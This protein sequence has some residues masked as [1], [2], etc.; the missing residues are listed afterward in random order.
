[1][2]EVVFKQIRDMED[3]IEDLEKRFKIINLKSF[4][5]IDDLKREAF[6]SNPDLMFGG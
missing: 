3:F 4:F 2:I 5:I 6:M 1:M